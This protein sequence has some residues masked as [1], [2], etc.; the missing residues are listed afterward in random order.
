MKFPRF[1]SKALYSSLRKAATGTGAFTWVEKEVPGVWWRSFRAGASIPYLPH[2]KESKNS[3]RPTP[4]PLIR[5]IPLISQGNRVYFS[6]A[7]SYGRSTITSHH[8]PHQHE[9]TLTTWNTKD[10][11]ATNFVSDLCLLIYRIVRAVRCR[12]RPQDIFAIFSSRKRTRQGPDSKRGRGNHFAG[13]V[14]KVTPLVMLSFRPSVALLR[15][16]FSFSVMSPRISMAF[17]APLGYKHGQP[18]SYRIDRGKTYAQLN[19]NREEVT[20]SL[21]GDLFTAWHTRKVNIAGLDEALST[22][23]SLEQLLGEP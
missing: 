15:S 9:M 23:N 10:R 18:S 21:L 2:N 4:Q 6:L 3:K 1:V 16:F 22:R 12:N 20:A 17:S 13:W 7:S 11:S 5:D 19:G 8:V 14:A